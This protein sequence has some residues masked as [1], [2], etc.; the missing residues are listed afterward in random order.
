MDKDVCARVHTYV[1]RW[2]DIILVSEP[3]N[4]NFVIFLLIYRNLI[5]F[6]DI[7]QQVPSQFLRHYIESAFEKLPYYIVLVLA[8]EW[9]L[10]LLEL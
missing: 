1:E 4:S 6:Y 5:S 2:V 8:A 10:R 7:S 9:L 3:P